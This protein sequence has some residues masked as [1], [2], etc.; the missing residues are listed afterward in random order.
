[1]RVRVCTYVDDGSR[2]P[3]F[4]KSARKKK[5]EIVEK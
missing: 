2:F 4:P 3:E 5:I 1:M